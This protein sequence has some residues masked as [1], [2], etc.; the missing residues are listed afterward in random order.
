MAETTKTEITRSPRY[1]QFSLK[2]AID[3]IRDVYKKEDRHRVP[4]EAIVKSIGYTTVNGASLGAIATLKQY[5]L[6]EPVGDG[7][8]VSDDAVT[9]IELPKGNSERADAILKTAFSPKLFAQLDD[10]YGAKP[11]SDESI[12][13]NLIR[14]GYKKAAA[15][16][17][18]RTFRETLALVADERG[19]YNAGGSTTE[20]RQPEGQP[21]MQQSPPPFTAHPSQ[22]ARQ[23]FNP[24]PDPNNALTGG[25][26]F[27][28][29]VS[30]EKQGTLIVPWTLNK[31]EWELLKRQIENSLFIAKATVLVEDAPIAPTPQAAGTAP[32]LSPE[33]ENSDIPDLFKDV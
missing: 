1:P 23:A 8:R 21:P 24:I 13:L 6:L 32:E 12:R 28:L 2:D 29:Y 26:V 14:K 3:K 10:E 25:M 22:E 27:P 30:R 31:Q 20:G 18:I 4:K 19:D 5:G 17:I 9:I 33:D 7:L 16:V 11:P 15:D